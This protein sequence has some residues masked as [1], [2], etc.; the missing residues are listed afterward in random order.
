M[1]FDLFSLNEVLGKN[2]KEV[3]RVIMEPSKASLPKK[4]FL[5]AA[6]EALPVVRKAIDQRSVER[7]SEA[8]ESKP[9]FDKG[10]V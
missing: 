1:G 10:T 2:K 8:E 6:E 9:L 7:Y 5:E 3:A 4:G